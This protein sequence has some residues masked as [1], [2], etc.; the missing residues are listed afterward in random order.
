[1][2]VTNISID[3]STGIKLLINVNPV[4]ISTIETTKRKKL[5][6]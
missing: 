2:I 6:L 4:K 1:M 5:L 3:L